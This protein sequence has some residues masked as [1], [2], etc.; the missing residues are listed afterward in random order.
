[1]GGSFDTAASVAVTREGRLVGML[2]IEDLLIAP[3]HVTASELMDD[4]PPTVTP[5]SNIESAAGRRSSTARA[6]LR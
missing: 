3:D 1:M 6:R 2:R 5:G 4:A